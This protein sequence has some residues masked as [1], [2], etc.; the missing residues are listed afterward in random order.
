[1]PQKIIINFLQIAH[2][3]NQLVY[4]LQEVKDA[5]GFQ[6]QNYRDLYRESTTANDYQCFCQ[7]KIN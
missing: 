2:I 5:L 7:S 4:K 3:I 6:N 1:M